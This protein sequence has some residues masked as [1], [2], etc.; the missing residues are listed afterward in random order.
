MGNWGR[1]FTFRW[2]NFT[3][4]GSSDC[5]AAGRARGRGGA[6]SADAFWAGGSAKRIRPGVVSGKSSR[7]GD[8]FGVFRGS[9]GLVS[10]G[11][12]GPEGRSG[13]DRAGESVRLADA[14]GGGALGARGGG[15]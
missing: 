15:A 11:E 9:T 14:G 2:F 8:G 4:R 3:G 6:A 7:A 5:V 12:E 10:F 1:A 13:Q